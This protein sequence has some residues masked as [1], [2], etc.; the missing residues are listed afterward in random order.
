MENMKN[1]IINA[2]E[3]KKAEILH[4]SHTIHDDPELGNEE[5]H[6]CDLLCSYLESQGFEVKKGIG[7]L[8]T[9]FTGTI[10]GK[11]GGPNIAVLAEYDAL[12]DIGHACGHNIIAAVAVGSAVAFK[13]VIG[14]YAG[15]ITVVGTPAEE[16]TG[17]KINLIENGVFEGFDFALEVHPTAGDHTIM[18]GGRACTTVYCDFTGVS[19]HS[20]APA[21]GVNAVSA[22]VETFHNIDALRPLFDS[23]DNVN[24]VIPYGG[25]ANNVIS[26]EARCEFC[27]R[28]VTLHNL[29]KLVEKV[30]HA[31]K[32]AAMLFGAEVELRVDPMFAER[33]PNRP[34]GLRFKAHLEDMG[35]TVV[36]A[37]PFGLYGSSDIGNVS[38][39]MPSIHEYIS[40]A[41]ADVNGHSAEMREAAV[42][43]RGDNACIMACKALALTILDL[44]ESEELRAEAKAFYENQLPDVYRK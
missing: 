2:I 14:D 27:L 34:M 26:G 40:I 30:K 39:L 18:R 5:Y 36:E 31:A 21:S 32:C 1:L 15:S 13:D 43:E 8:P 29:E 22:V 41:D 20:S 3:S 6:A 24:G 33:Y 12:K 17:G 23:M 38:L 19:A 42:S 44:L 10:K 11:D 16:T 35:E 7:G 37:N 28:S 25:G 4:L 9:A